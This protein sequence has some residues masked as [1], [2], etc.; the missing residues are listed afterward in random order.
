MA[1]PSNAALIR[2]GLMQFAEF[3]GEEKIRF[4]NLLTAVMTVVDTSVIS[5]GADLM[6]DETLESSANFLGPRYLAYPG[7]VE[8]WSGAKDIFAPAAQTWVDEQIRRSESG[9]DYW[10]IR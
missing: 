3:D 9:M 5:H 6:L 7:M 8:W 1:E 4:D 2:K 10:G